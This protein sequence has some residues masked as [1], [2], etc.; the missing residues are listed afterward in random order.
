MQIKARKLKSGDTIGVVATSEPITLEAKE[1]ID[2][3]VRLMNELGVNVRFAKYAFRNPTGYGESA[4]HK[5]EDI[6]AMFAD[7]EISRDFLCYG[8]F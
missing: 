8:W 3:S 1:Q 6:N 5:A 4:S 2:K 7:K